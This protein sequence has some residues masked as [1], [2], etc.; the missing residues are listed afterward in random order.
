MRLEL[1]A[2]EFRLV[3][4]WRSTMALIKVVVP[5][6]IALSAAILTLRS[7]P[8]VVEIGRLFGLW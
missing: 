6:I 1:N 5:L 8:E 2:E 4:K 7:V 3:I